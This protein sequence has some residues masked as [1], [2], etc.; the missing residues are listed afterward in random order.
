MAVSSQLSKTWHQDF[1]TYWSQL[2]TLYSREIFWHDQLCDRGYYGYPD[3]KYNGGSTELNPDL[4]AFHHDG[5]SQH[6]SIQ[7]FEDL[8]DQDGGY[9]SD[10]EDTVTSKIESLAKFHDIPSGEVSNWLELRD[11][12]F[13]PEFQEVIIL[14]PKSLY[15][16][17]NLE[18]ESVASDEDLIIWTIKPNG[19]SI[20]QKVFGDHSNRRLENAVSKGLKTYPNANDLLQYSR[21]TDTDYLKFEFVHK[22]VNHCAR[23]NKREFTFEE[24]DDIMTESQ[25]PI[26]GHLQREVRE[27]E[28]WRNFLYSMLQ[29]FKIIEQS[30]GENKYRW[31]RKKFLNE[32]RYQRRILEDVRSELGIGE[33]A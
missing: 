11:H 4:T 17:Y 13:E 31:K 27:E 1:T 8:K 5:D 22:L 21:K 6:F 16:V 33:N 26:L 30:E 3:P 19:A 18:I 7:C 25:P 29:R 9:V 15:D 24:I 28:F 14:V 32:P 23:E 12:E 20:V 2:Y 10:K